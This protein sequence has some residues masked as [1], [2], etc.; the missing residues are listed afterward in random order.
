MN[1]NAVDNLGD[2]AVT[3]YGRGRHPALTS[4]MLIEGFDDDVLDIRCRN[5]GNRSDLCRLGLTMQAWQRNIIPITDA[6]LGRMRRRHAVACV[7][8]QQSGQQVVACDPDAAPGG[9]LIRKLL[10]DRIEQGALHERRL[11]AWQDVAFIADLADIEPVAEQVEQRSP[12]ERDA[13][14][15]GAG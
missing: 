4:E 6:A 10:L 11:L 2:C 5:S 8:E 7:I 14:A 15:G 1:V 3:C 9:P 12:L 13:T